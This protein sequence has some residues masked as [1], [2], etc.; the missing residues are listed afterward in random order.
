MLSAQQKSLIVS[1]TYK[2]VLEFF[3]DYFGDYIFRIN[4]PENTRGVSFVKNYLFNRERLEAFRAPMY[5]EN[6]GHGIWNVMV[7]DYQHDAIKYAETHIYLNQQLYTGNI[8]LI[9]SRNSRRFS[10]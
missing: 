6:P 1:D 4:P 7:N 9:L 3:N 2:G 5:H 8:T 10:I